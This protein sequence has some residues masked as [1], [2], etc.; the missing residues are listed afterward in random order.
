MSDK[1]LKETVEDPRKSWADSDSE[2]EQE[3][4][5]GGLFETVED[6]TEAIPHGSTETGPRELTP[7]ERFQKG[8][9]G[10]G[11]SKTLE[12]T[13]NE[14][15]AFHP[16]TVQVKQYVDYFAKVTRTGQSMAFESVIGNDLN[17]LC[18]DWGVETDTK[19]AVTVGMLVALYRFPGISVPKQ[20]ND[21]REMTFKYKKGNDTTETILVERNADSYGK[22]ATEVWFR[23]CVTLA[24][25]A[26]GWIID[27]CACY[28]IKALSSS[29]IQNY[30]SS[31]YNTPCNSGAVL[32]IIR[33]AAPL[34]LPI[35]ETPSLRDLVENSLFVQYH[36]TAA[37]S[38]KLIKQ[39]LDENE[40][41]EHLF[42]KPGEREIVERAIENRW[43]ME[44]Q[45]AVPVEL[46]AVAKAYYD[47]INV[48]IPN[49]YQGKKAE[50]SVPATRYR[51]WVR[52][53]KRWVELN[54]DDR[55]IDKASNPEDLVSNA[56][57][58]MYRS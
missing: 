5:T 10:K 55:K 36:T 2:R 40:S 4:I 43:S 8:R 13:K 42:T 56:P 49:W 16:D 34:M 46:I 47:A 57:K 1:E 50:S 9:K 25:T 39:F 21:K 3:D 24:Y 15:D 22:D 14:D 30:F 17:L 54:A 37:S 7:L 29:N 28:Q 41:L 31:L 18:D 48:S 12:P 6:P 58:G 26:R 35:M 51:Q 19:G 52:F 27:L 53:F 38:A 23:S 44:Y 32:G 11:R 33:S 45:I 20:S